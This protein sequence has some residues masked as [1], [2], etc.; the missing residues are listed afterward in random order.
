MRV[1]CTAGGQTGDHI[2]SLSRLCRITRS[3][4]ILASLRFL[5]AVGPSLQLPLAQWVDKFLEHYCFV[6]KWALL[7]P[8]ANREPRLP[9]AFWLEAFN[10][11]KGRLH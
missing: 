10:Y 3:P 2:T 9:T 6:A 8:Q 4:H 7:N 5:Q 1:V 11:P